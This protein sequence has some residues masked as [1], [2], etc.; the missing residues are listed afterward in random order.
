MDCHIWLQ[1]SAP[2]I[3]YTSRPEHMYPAPFLMPAAQFHTKDLPLSPVPCQ[4]STDQA[5]PQSDEQKPLYLFQRQ[6]HVPL[7]EVHPLRKDS[8]LQ[9]HY[10]QP[11]S[12]FYNL[13]EDEHFPQMDGHVLPIGYVRAQYCL[14]LAVL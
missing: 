7:I 10:E 12:H 2:G 3:L 1:Q 4:L 6:I 5:L 14:V 13:Y 11:Q 9:S 8:F